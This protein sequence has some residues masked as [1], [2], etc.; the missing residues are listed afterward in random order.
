MPSTRHHG[1][2]VSPLGH[3]TR[4]EPADTHDI[5]NSIDRLN[6]VENFVMIFILRPLITVEYSTAKTTLPIKTLTHS[7][8]PTRPLRDKLFA[9][10]DKAVAPRDKAVA[11]RNKAAAP[12]NKAAARLAQLLAPRDWPDL[13]LEN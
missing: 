4:Y 9:P 1:L 5:D 13:R 6:K 2:V 12:R 10:R 11:P 8:K 3:R 7:R